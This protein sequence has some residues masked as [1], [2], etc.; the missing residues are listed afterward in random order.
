M[1]YQ[2]HVPDPPR[3][4]S[5]CLEA[6]AE[7]LYFNPLPRWPRCNPTFEDHFWKEHANITLR[8]GA[9]S[10]PSQFHSEQEL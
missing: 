10:L 9:V 2:T 4:E 7:N 5:G 8:A 6:E 1:A 3:P